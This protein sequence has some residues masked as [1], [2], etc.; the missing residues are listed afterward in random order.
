MYMYLLCTNQ[1]NMMWIENGKIQCTKLMFN[2]E[3]DVY[4][5]HFM[6]ETKEG[7]GM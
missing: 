6:C 7:V 3:V 1:S 4:S 5:S 2:F